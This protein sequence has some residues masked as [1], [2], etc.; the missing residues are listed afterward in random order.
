M[1]I[2]AARTTRF[3][4]D[5][6]RCEP[7]TSFAVL[8]LTPVIIVSATSLFALLSSQSVGRMATPKAIIHRLSSN[9][10]FVHFCQPNG[11]LTTDLPDGA[12]LCSK[13]NSLYQKL[14]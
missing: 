4:L 11:A 12:S 6:D 2:K 10:N 8:D 3:G 1:I 9:C 13:N 7:E 5:R 14:K